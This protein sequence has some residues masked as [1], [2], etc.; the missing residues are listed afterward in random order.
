MNEFVFYSLIV[1]T[2]VEYNGV[3]VSKELGMDLKID[4]IYFLF[5]FFRIIAKTYWVYHYVEIM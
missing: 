3:G 5:F 2:C 1:R 4:F